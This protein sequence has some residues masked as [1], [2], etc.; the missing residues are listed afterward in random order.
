MPDH[1]NYECMVFAEC[2]VSPITNPP[3]YEKIKILRCLMLKE[4]NPERWNL[5]MGLES[6]AEVRKQ[7]FYAVSSNHSFFKFIKQECMMNFSF[8]EIH[9]AAGVCAVNSY[10]TSGLLGHGNSDGHS[11]YD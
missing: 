7:N 11:R 8:E 6:H 2:P 1:A 10:G 4:K 9:H 3:E 5:L